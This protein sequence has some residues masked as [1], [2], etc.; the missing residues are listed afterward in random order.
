MA[1]GLISHQNI[2]RIA[3]TAFL[4]DESGLHHSEQLIRDRCPWRIY[5]RLNLM[6]RHRFLRTDQRIDTSGQWI[7]KKRFCL[8]EK[9]RQPYFKEP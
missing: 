2:N 3:A 5:D 8:R 7:T 6:P 1:Y 4:S 9:P